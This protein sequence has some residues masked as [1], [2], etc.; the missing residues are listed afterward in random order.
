MAARGGAAQSYIALGLFQLV[1]DLDE[2]GFSA[3]AGAGNADKFSGSNG[4][5]NVLQNRLVGL[6]WVG[7]PDAVQLHIVAGRDGGRGGNVGIGKIQW[8]FQ[9]LEVIVGQYHTFGEFIQNPVQF[10]QRAGQLGKAQVGG[11]HGADGDDTLGRQQNRNSD[12]QYAEESFIY[13]LQAVIQRHGFVMAHFLFAQL[14]GLSFNA[15]AFSLSA[16]QCADGFNT[17]QQFHHGAVHIGLGIHQF[18]TDA[19]LCADLPE[20]NKCAYGIRE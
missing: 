18:Y 8:K 5:I 9:Q 11:Q 13:K 14:F 3:A 1:N 10:P 2:G 19:L 16:V 20:D 4:Q 15:Q 6:F 12:D 17:A 7:K